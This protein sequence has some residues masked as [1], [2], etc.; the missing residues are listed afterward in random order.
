MANRSKEWSEDIAKKLRKKSYRRDFFIALVEDE[1]LSIRQAIQILAKT[2]GHREFSD[3]VQIAPPN[4]SRVTNPKNDVRAKTLE[5]ILKKI[6]LAL[7]I[8]AI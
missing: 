4:A 1:G 5:S 3:L 6:G 2:M 7:T 8:K